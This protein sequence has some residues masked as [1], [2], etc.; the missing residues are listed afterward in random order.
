M[1]LI[2]NGMRISAL[3]TSGEIEK[4]VKDC[5]TQNPVHKNK[6][7]GQDFCQFSGHFSP[8]KGLKCFV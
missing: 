1:V 8:R 2:K 5:K 6:F 3:L 4:T 7:S